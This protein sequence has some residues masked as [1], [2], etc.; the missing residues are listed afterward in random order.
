LPPY[1]LLLPLLGPTGNLG[2]RHGPG[3]T[4]TLY[5]MATH[6]PQ[7]HTVRQ[8]LYA[9][10]DDLTPEHPRQ[11]DDTGD[12]AQVVTVFQHAAHETLVDL[13]GIYR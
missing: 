7:S 2:G 5:Q 6:L 3:D 9:L 13:Q 8:R 4:V 1:A 11:L 10:G 12:N